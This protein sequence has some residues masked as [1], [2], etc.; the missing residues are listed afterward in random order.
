MKFCFYSFILKKMS[1]ST[2]D[3]YTPRQN[4]K[5]FLIIIYNS[6]LFNKHANK[7]HKDKLIHILKSPDHE[8]EIED[9]IHIFH[10]L[11]KIIISKSCDICSNREN[12]KSILPEF[13]LTKKFEFINLL[14]SLYEV[15]LNL[16]QSVINR[17]KVVLSTESG[18]FALDVNYLMLSELKKIKDENNVYYG[19]YF[20]FSKVNNIE[21][22]VE[23]NHFLVN[24]ILSNRD[25][26]GIKTAMLVVGVG[27][28]VTNPEHWCGIFIDH[29][30]RNFYY[31]NSLANPE[32][33]NLELFNDLNL[34]SP[35]KPYKFITNRYG[36]QKHNAL[37]G[38]FSI[39]FLLNMLKCKTSKRLELFENEYNVNCNLDKLYEQD[40]Q[41][42]Y[43]ILASEEKL[44]DYTSLLKIK[45]NK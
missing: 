20:P 41:K 14:N 31:Y 4:F 37:C 27:K 29:E 32:Q 1:A 13:L 2:L 17:M 33:I 24:Y 25:I 8:I 23:K 44:K 30:T 39:H 26:N 42:K 16:A 10:Y 3:L 43:L 18:M 11:E 28:K 38:I 35:Y 45:K 36:Q 34:I 22:V 15:P 6:Y 9:L 40:I 7:I 21:Q 12:Y 19:V 5:N